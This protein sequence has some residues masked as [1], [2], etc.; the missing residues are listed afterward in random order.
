M[1]QPNHYSLRFLSSCKTIESELI[2]LKPKLFMKSEIGIINCIKTLSDSRMQLLLDIVQLASTTKSKTMTMCN[3]NITLHSD[4]SEFQ[5]IDVLIV[6]ENLLNIWNSYIDRTKSSDTI[7]YIKD[8]QDIIN[9]HRND[10]RKKVAIINDHV[11]DKALIS[12]TAN[13]YNIRKLILDTCDDLLLPKELHITYQFMWIVSFGFLDEYDNSSKNRRIGFLKNIIKDLYGEYTKEIYNKITINIE[14]ASIEQTETFIESK[15]NSYTNITDA[16]K[17]DDISHAVCLINPLIFYTNESAYNHI[18]ANV[19]STINHIDIH[20]NV[21]DKT[22]TERLLGLTKKKHEYEKIYDSCIHRLENSQTCNICIDKI[23]HKT[24]LKCCKTSFCFRCLNT[25]LQMNNRC[26]IC[27]NRINHSNDQILIPEINLNIGK[28]ILSCN[29]IYQNFIIMV[30]R[31]KTE[32]VLIYYTSKFILNLMKAHHISYQ[33][34]NNYQ[35]GSTSN[36][37]TVVTNPIVGCGMEYRFDHLIVV[38]DQ[39]QM[40]RNKLIN[41]Y[42]PKNVWYICNET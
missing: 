16:L 40:N 37:I 11:M 28:E 19:K 24:I 25:W 14:D 18:L 38:M 41:I 34:I 33:T 31:L 23:E 5:E 30:K 27:K 12:L 15:F 42:K 32:S 8:I 29:S 17:D 35:Y 21:I 13:G 9:L 36:K 20:M 22:N 26:P 7:V 10:D 1:V 39:K 6:P 4:P 2:T 3:N